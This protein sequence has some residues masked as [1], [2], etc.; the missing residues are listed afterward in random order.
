MVDN[1]YLSWSYTS[2]PDNK[3]NTY[4]VIQFYEWSESMR[5]DV[6][7]LFGIMKVRFTLLQYGFRFHSIENYD[8]MWLTCFALHNLLLNVDGLDKN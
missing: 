2:P 7:C 5:K 6:E 8:K 3:W 1:G 4:E